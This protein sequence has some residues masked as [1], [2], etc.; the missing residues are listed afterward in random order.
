M[1][2]ARR[3][4]PSVAPPQPPPPPQPVVAAGGGSVGFLAPGFYTG[5][6]QLPPG[7]YA[8]EHIVMMHNPIKDNG[9]K[10]WKNDALG[11]MLYAYSLDK[12]GTEPHEQFLSLGSKAHL[13]FVPS[14]DGKGLE[15]IPG[16]ASTG[17]PKLTNWGIYFKS[18]Q[19]CGL[20]E[21]VIAAHDISGLDGIWVVTD[22]VPEPEERKGF[23]RNATT[24][25]AAEE[26]QEERKGS[27]KTVIVTEIIEGGKPWEG[28]GGFPDA[29][30]APPAPP[31]PPAARA[32]APARPAP[33]AVGPRAVPPARPAVQPPAAA[34]AASQDD[35]M[36]AASAGVTEVLSDPANANGCA[37]LKVRTG[38]FKYVKATYGDEMAQAVTALFDSGDDVVNAVLG[39]LG[40]K[41]SGINVVLA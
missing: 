6:F 25:E 20:V 8:M 23:A 37:K 9:Q 12:P 40:Y 30:V 22:L 2:P 5:G 34:P 14:A 13:S 38:A 1:P 3:Q 11:V 19:D 29:T 26:P 27:G 32:A 33:A 28:G 39:P 7:R 31:A 18:L 41:V 10:A 35:V 36:A 16:G 4:P 24:S 15:P 21:G 17:A